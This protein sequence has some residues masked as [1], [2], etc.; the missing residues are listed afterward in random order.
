MLGSVYPFR[1][2]GGSFGRSSSIVFWAYIGLP[3][4]VPRVFVPSWT[5]ANLYTASYCSRVNEAGLSMNAVDFFVVSRVVTARGR[6]WYSINISFFTMVNVGNYCQCFPCWLVPSLVFCAIR[7]IA[8]T[9]VLQTAAHGI[10][11]GYIFFVARMIH[12][13]RACYTGMTDT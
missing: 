9:C 4:G 3:F 10:G 7:C 6:D 12:C 11:P 8:P 1:A 5:W 13:F 2:L